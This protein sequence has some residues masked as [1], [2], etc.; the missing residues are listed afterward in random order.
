[1]QYARPL[2]M[3]IGGAVTVKAVTGRLHFSLSHFSC[4]L[5]TG[6]YVQWTARNVYVVQ[7]LLPNTSWGS[8]IVECT[9]KDFAISDFAP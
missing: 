4:V 1:M 6:A 7:V 8:R 9:Q 2:A 3:T 5:L